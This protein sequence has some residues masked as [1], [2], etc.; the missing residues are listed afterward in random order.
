MAGI[1]IE[2]NTSGNVAEITS[3]NELKV[4][5]PNTYVDGLPSINGSFSNNIFEADAGSITGSP[6]QRQGDISANYRQRV[7]VDTLLFND[8]FNGIALNSSLWSNTS[9]TFT[10]VVSNG[11]LVLKIV[12]MLS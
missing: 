5:G 3:N 1:R 10:T 2:G 12:G 8:Q 6:T 4:I 7:G 11:F 9:T